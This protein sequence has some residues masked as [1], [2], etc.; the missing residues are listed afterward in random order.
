LNRVAATFLTALVV[1]CGCVERTIEVKT[2]PPGAAV[3]IDRE[4]RGLSPLSFPFHH[5]GTREVTVRLE[6]YRTESRVRTLWPIWY[7]IFP[8]AFFF[9]CIFP[10]TLHDRR[11][12]RFELEK[13][14]PPPPA[15]LERERDELLKR[16]E[17][18]RKDVDR[19]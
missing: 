9:D 7:Q 2:D 12:F 17:E 11:H 10:F 19:D 6:G 13:E 16:A 15:D 4:F 5:Y 3:F 8:L 1:L 18:L 14:T